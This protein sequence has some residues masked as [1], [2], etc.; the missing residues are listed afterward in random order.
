M[1]SLPV[2]FR[3]APP[4]IVNYDWADISDGM[5]YKTI[6]AGT[7]SKNDFT[8][9]GGILSTES[10]YSQNVLSASG[11][12]VNATYGK[13]HEQNFDSEI[14]K[15]LTLKG[16]AIFQIPMGVESR[17]GGGTDFVFYPNVI[18]KQVKDGVET[19][20]ATASGAQ[21]YTTA[22]LTTYE[23]EVAYFTIGGELPRTIL[24][25]GNKLRLTIEWWGRTNST[26]GSYVMIAH[27]PANRYQCDFDNKDWI[28]DNRTDLIFYMPLEIDL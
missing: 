28:V 9:S 12:N 4:T 16:N 6:Y 10:F 1:A 18:I 23:R 11:A 19:K 7:I 2:Q 15:N 21:V 22:S 24:R 17:D 25:K 13:H 27:D 3:K 14:N 26:G 8:T 20:I 5:G